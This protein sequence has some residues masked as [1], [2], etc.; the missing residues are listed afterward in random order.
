[1]DMN[2]TIS[3]TLRIGVIASALCM[4]IGLIFIAVNNGAGG[5]AI[6]Q[7]ELNTKATSTA[8]FSLSSMLSG[9]TQLNGFD[10]LFLGIL[11]LVATP[12]LR[13]FLS[14]LAFTFERNWLY[15]VITII[16]F[17]NLLIALFI[18]PGLAAH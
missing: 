4:V 3:I 9:M 1:M 15:T 2:N 17:A 11:I 12:V 5:I 8:S 18:M 16:V 6:Q 10:F 13:V 7:L 14:I